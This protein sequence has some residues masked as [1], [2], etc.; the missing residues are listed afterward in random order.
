[1]SL[2]DLLKEFEGIIGALL[3]VAMTMV[4]TRWLESWG[5]T[6][7]AFSDVAITYYTRDKMGGASKTDCPQNAEWLNGSFRLEVFN[8]ASTGKA[9]TGIKAL[10][11]TKHNEI[12]TDL[13]DLNTGRF[14]AASMRYDKVP[15]I[16]LRPKE[17]EGYELQFHLNSSDFKDTSIEKITKLYF[18]ATYT[19]GRIIKEPVWAE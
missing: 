14:V 11:V 6:Q 5:K 17:I 15:H 9:V 3:G 2:V 1:M 19:N 7:F 12:E 18:V 10:I 13:S 8:G 16:S 4:M